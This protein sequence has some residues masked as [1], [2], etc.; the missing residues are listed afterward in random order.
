MNK[1]QLAKIIHTL[2]NTQENQCFEVFKDESGTETWYCAVAIL[3]KNG[4]TNGDL[5]RT[6]VIAKQDVLDV[7]NSYPPIYDRVMEGYLNDQDDL[8]V[9]LVGLNDKLYLSFRQIAD[10]LEALMGLAK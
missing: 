4:Y 6:A 2:R 3:N 1:G 9:L 5:S 8:Y 7:L 10:V